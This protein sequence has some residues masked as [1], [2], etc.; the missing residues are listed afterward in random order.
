M[1]KISLIILAF[2][3]IASTASGVIFIRRA[4]VETCMTGT[5]AFA[6][7]GDHTNGTLYACLS[8]GATNETST[9]NS[10]TP[11]EVDGE[12][13]YGAKV[14][15][16]SDNIYWADSSDTRINDAVGTVWVRVYLSAQP[17][18]AHNVLFSTATTANPLTNNVMLVYRYDSNKI[19]GFFEAQA[20]VS[21][22]N[23][24]TP[25]LT[26]WVT[27]GYTWDQANGK[28]AIVNT[29]SWASP[30]D[31]DTGELP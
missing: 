14:T 11:A 26:T 20:G 19:S 31:E 7:D 5:Y 22:V 27:V 29:N 1:K 13:G 23:W 17:D 28:H 10:I 30:T 25:T 8:S 15:Q 24:A 21:E 18:D 2:M 16:R 4:V 12:T 3:V 6:W 9:G